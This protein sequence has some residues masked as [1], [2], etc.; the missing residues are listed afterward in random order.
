LAAPTRLPLSTAA[1]AGSL[2]GDM[3]NDVIDLELRRLSD[4][5]LLAALDDT[6]LVLADCLGDEERAVERALAER[7]IDE[8]ERRQQ[9]R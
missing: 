5:A 1:V 6:R 7:L 2:F 3:G 8:L 9:G 4:G